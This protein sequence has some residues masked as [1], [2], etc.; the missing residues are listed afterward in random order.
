MLRHPIDVVVFCLAVTQAVSTSCDAITPL[1]LP[2]K[3]IQ[4]MPDIE[5]SLMRG[6]AAKVGFPEQDI[7]L[8][9]WP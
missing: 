9:P 3:D 7:V 5:D 1:Q 8:L 4:A 6:V 2:I